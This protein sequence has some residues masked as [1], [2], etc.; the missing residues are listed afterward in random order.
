MRVGSAPLPWLPNQTHGKGDW[1]D[2]AFHRGLAGG[3]GR[4]RRG[5]PSND[6]SAVVGVFF[7]SFH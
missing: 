7:I 6:P 1:R 5:R 3:V 4:K 2:T